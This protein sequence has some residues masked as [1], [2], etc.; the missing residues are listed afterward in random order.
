MRVY[1]GTYGKY[2]SGDLGGAWLDVEDYSDKDEFL[3]ACQELHGKGDHEFMFQDHEGIPEKYISETSISGDLWDE[4]VPLNDSEKEIVTL[5]WDNVDDSVDPDSVQDRYMG[6][7]DSVED[8][9]IEYVKDTTNTSNLGW[10][11]N[12]I[13]YK[14]MARDFECGDI[15]VVHSGGQV[16]IFQTM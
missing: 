8:Y 13:D 9:C 12:Y 1:V 10:L 5:Y 14:A 2:N 3:E 7:H 6:T 11:E 4:F 16:L 15:D